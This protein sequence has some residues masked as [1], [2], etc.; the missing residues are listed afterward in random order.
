[1]RNGERAGN[2]PV[3]QNVGAQRATD[4]IEQYITRT[5][6]AAPP[7]TGEQRAHLAELLAPVRRTAAE[8]EPP[9]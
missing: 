3:V 6:A 7:L 9:K 4:L 8:A 5:L 2:D 1:V